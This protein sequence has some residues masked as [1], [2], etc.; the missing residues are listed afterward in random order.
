MLYAQ[1]D[2][3]YMPF[4][5]EGRVLVAESNDKAFG[6]HDEACLMLTG[7]TVVGGHQAT[8]AYLR[9][10]EGPA[11]NCAVFEENRKVYVIQRGKQE[12]TLLMTSVFGKLA[13]HIL[14]VRKKL[15]STK[16]TMSP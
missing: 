6:G 5:Q 2:D 9:L 1:E 4:V 16:L 3:S 10:K 7:D 11:Y 8:K 14:R 15:F 12:A 13:T